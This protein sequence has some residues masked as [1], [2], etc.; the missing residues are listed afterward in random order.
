M[1]I[2][3]TTVTNGAATSIYTSSGASAITTIHIANRTGSTVV[4]NVYVV[5]N[6]SSAGDET[7]IYSNYSI[8]AHNTL[9]IYQEKFILDDSDAI[10]ANCDTSSALTATVS[11]IGI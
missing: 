4:A 7:V 6:G 2:Q 3:N 10:F 11:S 5:P 1:A 9:I 8:T